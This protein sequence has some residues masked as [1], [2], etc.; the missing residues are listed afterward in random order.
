[1]LIFQTYF[2]NMFL[3]M[4]FSVDITSRINFNYTHSVE[5]ILQKYVS[6]LLDI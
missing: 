1:M 6:Y 3:I 4:N 5:L 2:T